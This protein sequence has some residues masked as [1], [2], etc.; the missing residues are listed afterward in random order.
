MRKNKRRQQARC[1]RTN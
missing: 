1:A